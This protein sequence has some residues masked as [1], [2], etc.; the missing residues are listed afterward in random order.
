VDAALQ[1]SAVVRA[2]QQPSLAEVLQVPSAV[3]LYMLGSSCSKAVRQQLSAAVEVDPGTTAQAMVAHFR[4]CAP[5][6]AAAKVLV[7]HGLQAKAMRA[8]QAARED[9]VA[10][11]DGTAPQVSV[12]KV[13]RRW[14]Q[15]MLDIAACL[16]AALCTVVVVLSACTFGPDCKCP[17]KMVLVLL[18]SRWPKLVT[19]ATAVHRIQQHNI[20]CS[21]WSRSPAT[22]L[23]QQ[24][25][26][27]QT[28]APSCSCWMLDIQPGPPLLQWLLHSK[29]LLMATCQ[30][31]TYLR[32]A[33]QR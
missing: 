28:P 26:R 6:A 13:D 27:T 2:M 9:T 31:W 33:T 1:L 11:S 15:H 7:I 10:V 25:H 19:P 23:P 22:R 18:L 16:Q 32:A 8:L 5:V 12:Q 29:R 21:G 17:Q 14:L 30:V 4:L 24:R 3:E 20:A